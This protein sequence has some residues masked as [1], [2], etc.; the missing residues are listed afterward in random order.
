MDS[1]GVIGYIHPTGE[2]EV[3]FPDTIPTGDP[4]KIVDDAYLPLAYD[5]NSQR[6]EDVTVL[7]R[8]VTFSPSLYSDPTSSPLARAT[9]LALA[10]DEIPREISL[11]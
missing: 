11:E 6:D 9:N 5:S 3:I 1:I 2:F 8:G 10:T 7:R 4:I